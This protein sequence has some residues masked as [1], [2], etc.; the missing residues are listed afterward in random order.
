MSK[1]VAALRLPLTPYQL[2][3][4]PVENMN[5]HGLG[6]YECTA[7]R[8]AARSFAQARYD[9]TRVDTAEIDGGSTV[10]PH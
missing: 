3:I 6:W 10:A 5:A 2:K 1:F 8:C 9:Q 7:C 4:E